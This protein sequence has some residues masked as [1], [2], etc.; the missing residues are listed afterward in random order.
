MLLLGSC[1]VAAQV[2]AGRGCA[3]HKSLWVQ[4]P[5]EQQKQNG[6]VRNPHFVC[7]LCEP[8]VA[9]LEAPTR[10]C[11]LATSS[12][13]SVPASCMVWSSAAAAGPRTPPK[14][15]T[16]MWCRRTGMWCRRTP[17][18][19]TA[20]SGVASSGAASPRCVSSVLVGVA[21]MGAALS[22]EDMGRDDAIALPSAGVTAGQNARN[23]FG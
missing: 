21:S 2:G 5:K 15:S 19:A 13:A 16:G 11:V 14:G 1:A 9:H 10:G 12:D 17:S 3:Q 6:V 23:S 22:S 20:T 4:Q 18:V 8:C 7:V